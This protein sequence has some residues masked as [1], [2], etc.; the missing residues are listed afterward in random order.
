MGKLSNKVVSK[1]SKINKSDIDN[2]D[3]DSLRTIL[4]SNKQVAIASPPTNVLI[5][6]LNTYILCSPL[7]SSSLI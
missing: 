4:A 3:S 1:R 2:T 6:P 5:N 7:I